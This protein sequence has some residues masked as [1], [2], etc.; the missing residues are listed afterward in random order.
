M[1]WYAVDGLDGS[2]KSTA[3]EALRRILE[4]EGRTVSVITHPDRNTFP[5]RM[6]SRLLL[7]NGKP[8]RIFAAAF[9]MMDILSSVRYGKR[10][11]A[12]DV[13]FVRYTLS[14]A[15]LPDGLANAALKIMTCILPKPD[16]GIY[17]DVEEE[18]ALSRIGAR[19][20]ERETFENYGDL[21]NVRRKMLSMSEGWHIVDGNMCAKDVE[22][23]LR[24]LAFGEAGK[25]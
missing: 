20:E 9:L 16:I 13:I 1:T 4:S 18:V 25:S 5:G 10:T 11:A 8:A 24:E 3:A 7:K 12:D 17:I 14:A 15:Y 23:A 21:C 22:S 6:T 2:G 19:G